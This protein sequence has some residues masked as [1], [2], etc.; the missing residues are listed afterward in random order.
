MARAIQYLTFTMPNIAYA[1]QQVCL[2]MHA[3]RESYLTAVKCILRY[4]KGTLDHDLLLHYA[5]TSDLVI[6]TDVD[7]AGCPDI[8][9]STSGYAVFLCDKLIS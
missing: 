5:S 6:Y 3:P 4:L 8:H 1:V 7:W 9:R 2:H